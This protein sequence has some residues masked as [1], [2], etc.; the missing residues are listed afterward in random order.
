M[1]VS[2]KLHQDLGDASDWSTGTINATA[3]D[4]VYDLLI[5]AEAALQGIGRL[6]AAS[7]PSPNVSTLDER[8]ELETVISDC[9]TRLA[10]LN[11]THGDKT[12]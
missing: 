1:S 3:G 12:D 11:Y 5:G 6:N 9:K 4:E 8:T 10:A 7:Q 2:I